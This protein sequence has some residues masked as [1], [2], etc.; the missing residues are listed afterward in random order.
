MEEKELNLEA[1]NS[2]SLDGFLDD[3]DSTSKWNTKASVFTNLFSEV[4]Y[5]F[6]LY[7][8][9]HPEDK[10]IRQR[11]EVIDIMTTLFDQETI[12]KNHDA[13]VRREERRDVTGLMN[14]LLKNG[15]GDDA[16]KASEDESFLNK[17]LAEFRSGMMMAK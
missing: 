1:E 12:M 9:L 8:A 17:L 11:E 10:D 16:I 4:E 2:V 6:Q 7:K 15:R 5:R 14:Y 13:T 3:N